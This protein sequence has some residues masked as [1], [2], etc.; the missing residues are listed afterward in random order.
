M[1][2]TYPH[3]LEAELTVLGAILRTDGAALEECKALGLP[4]GDFYRD[5]H[6]ALYDLLLKR[7]EAGLPLDEST[8]IHDLARKPDLDRFGGLAYV[9]AVTTQC[10]AIHNTGY[11]AERVIELAARRRLIR[12]AEALMSQAADVDVSIEDVVRGAE[13]GLLTVSGAVNGSGRWI[14][15]LEIAERSVARLKTREAARDAGEVIGLPWGVVELDY[16]PQRVPP[17]SRK[18]LYVGAARPAMGKSS[19]A[20]GTVREALRTG[21]AVAVFSLEME[22]DSIGDKLIALEE[23]FPTARL[24]DGDIGEDWSKVYKACDSISRY[25]I[26]LDTTPDR[27]IDQLRSRSR[28]LAAR[29]ARTDTPLGLIVVDYLQLVRVKGQQSK[30][31]AVAETSRGLLA[32][33][34][35][36]SVPVFAL[37]QLN[38][39]CEKRADRRP[40]KSDLRGSGQI[41]Q[42]A[43]GLLF[44][45]RHEVYEPGEREAE[46]EIII[47]KMRGGRTGTVVVPWDSEIQRFGRSDRISLV[48]DSRPPVLG[49]PR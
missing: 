35:E 15:G 42:D 3:D 18:R 26:F 13:K 22:E 31:D 25:P 27:T 7:S 30:E 40:Q 24:R 1:K 38:R 39:D 10:V 44:F 6:Y 49:V 29:M 8:V 23:R 36:C 11:F 34:K 47:D 2:V 41:E 14:T 20:L 4:P 5:A 9:G 17:M 43:Y 12:Q 33:A 21:N 46:A 37:A 28:L 48:H 19:F 16:G 32:M 45:Y